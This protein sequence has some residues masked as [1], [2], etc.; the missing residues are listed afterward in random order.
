MK[1]LPRCIGLVV[2]GEQI[3]YALPGP[4]EDHG[5][6]SCQQNIKNCRCLTA[7]FSKGF[8]VGILL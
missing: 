7:F 4:M 6:D 8:H 5:S 2:I 1:S 3:C